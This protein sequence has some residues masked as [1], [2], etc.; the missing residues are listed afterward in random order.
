MI[1]SDFLLRRLLKIPV[2]TLIYD[3]RIENTVTAKL[4][5]QKQKKKDRERKKKKNDKID[6]S[7]NLFRNILYSEKQNFCKETILY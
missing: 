3:Q 5:F 4:P 7:N 2:N 6:I 1:L